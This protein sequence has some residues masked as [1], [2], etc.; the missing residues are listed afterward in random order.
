MELILPRYC[1]RAFVS[2]LLVSQ[3]ILVAA[4]QIESYN[5]SIV[6]SIP[7]AK[8]MFTSDAG[9]ASAGAGNATTFATQASVDT[10]LGVVQVQFGGI[11]SQLTSTSTR[12]NGIDTVNN[13]LQTQVN[14]KKR[15]KKRHIN[16]HNNY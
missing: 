10:A 11:Q 13:G 2:F 14:A 1:L 3:Y 7:G 8:M 16:L 6:F 12:I 4:Q 5:G 9:T 15:K